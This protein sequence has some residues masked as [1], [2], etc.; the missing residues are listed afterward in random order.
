MNFVAN[1]SI[2]DILLCILGLSVF[3]FLVVKMWSSNNPKNDTTQKKEKKSDT[4]DNP[5]NVNVN[6]GT[7]PADSDKA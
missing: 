5:V 6:V 2:A 3:C 4:Q 7:K 1:V